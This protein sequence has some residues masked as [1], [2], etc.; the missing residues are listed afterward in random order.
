ML[1]PGPTGTQRSKVTPPLHPKGLLFCVGGNLC[2]H[3]EQ[4]SSSHL[5][6]ET[7]CLKAASDTQPFL[8]EEGRSFLGARGAQW[9]GS[10]GAKGNK[11]RGQAKNWLRN[12]ERKDLKGRLG[13]VLMSAALGIKSK[14][15][16]L[17]FQ[18]PRAQL[19]LLFHPVPLLPVGDAYGFFF[20]FF[21]RRNLFPPHSLE[22]SLSGSLPTGIL[23][24][25]LSSAKMLGSQG[26]P[27]PSLYPEHP[28]PTGHCPRK[29][30]L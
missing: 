6:G 12:G 15:L 24:I 16:T 5:G 23:L 2:S 11:K 14:C 8:P 21:Y 10:W 18:G 3:L 7:R 1:G 30:P 17:A 28:P 27:L 4:V 22:L 13:L 25:I 9:Q 20:F 29:C 19:P 26:G